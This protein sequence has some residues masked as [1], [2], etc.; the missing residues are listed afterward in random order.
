MQSAPNKSVSERWFRL[1]L[2]LYPVDFRD[3]MGAGF[4]EAYLD[5]ARIASARGGSIALAGVW[6]RALADSVI[7]GIGERFRPAVAWRR[8]GNWG[9]DGEL[10]LRRLVRAPVFSLAMIGTLV[11]GLGAFGVVFTVVEKIL[12]EPL[13]YDRPNDLYFVWRDYGPLLDLQRGWLGGPDVA[14][15]GKVGGPILASA[16]LRRDRRTIA[17]PRAAEGSPEEIE[18]HD[19]SPNLFDLLGV[20]PL[21][22]RGFTPTEVGEGRAPV[23]VLGYDLWQ[24]RF[25]GKRSVLG[26]PVKLNGEVFTVIGVMPRDFH[27]VRHTSL[28]APEPADAYVTFAYSLAAASPRSGFVRGS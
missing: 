12:I 3:E 13:P 7:N 20:R 6:L 4:V 17:D 16:G 24:R 23:M 22:G 25:D 21:L 2:S 27:F 18:R 5:R 28:G 8:A 1:L 9:R 14:E 10:A 11:V 19:S 15:L 26:T